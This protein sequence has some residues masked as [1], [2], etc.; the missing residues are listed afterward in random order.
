M[1][2]K[3]KTL[4]RMQPITRRYA[5]VINDLGGVLRRLQNLTEEIGR[6][7]ADSRALYK[8]SES[9]SGR[10]DPDPEGDL[11]WPI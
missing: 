4:R 3:K 9:E 2:Y 7:E 8:R 5:R 1:A 10:K 6:L 11:Q